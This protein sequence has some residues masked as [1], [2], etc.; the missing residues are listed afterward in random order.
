MTGRL[1]HLRVLFAEALGVPQV[2]PAEHFLAAGG[3]LAAARRLVGRVRADLGVDL[4]LRDFLKS[5]TPAGLDARCGGDPVAPAAIPRA[6]AARPSTGD[7]AIDAEIAE[8]LRRIT[9]A[10]ETGS[11]APDALVLLTGASGFV[12]AFV[13]AALLARGQRVTVLLRGGLAR[14]AGLV[15]HL[16]GLGLWR[17]DYADALEIVA[18]DLAAP[19]LGLDP[20]AR[21]A[22]VR[23]ASRIVHCAAW[24]NHV[25]PYSLLAAANAHSAAE[26]L[27]LAATGRPKSVTHV[28]TKGVLSAAHYPQDTVITAGPVVGLPPEGDGYGRSKAVAEA[29][30]AHAAELGVRASIV[31]IPGVFGDRDAY[32]IQKNDAV[33]SWTKAILLTGRYPN[34]YDLADNEL[35]QALPADVVAQVVLDLA[36]PA[37]EPGCRFV[38]AVPNRVCTTRDF[39][40]GLREA[41]HAVEPMDDRAWHREV[42]RLDVDEVWVAA[43][44]GSLATHP[45][46]GDPQ[47]LPRFA[48]DEDPAVSE[49]VESAAI[50]TPRDVAGYIRALK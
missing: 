3:D 34:S 37:D 27:E 1:E 19:A 6:A 25:L 43:V 26:I 50:R 32:Q 28:S 4:S 22:L 48:V 46:I 42:G 24:V 30:I 11:A 41:G 49:A 10:P 9:P 29:Y 40:A 18:G 39:V 23:D 12:G 31:R 20:A 15:A 21:D 7:A 17:E 16:E 47:R 45:E 8:R 13:L 5:P 2:G 14:R 35:F 36:H 44:A 38:N 33:W